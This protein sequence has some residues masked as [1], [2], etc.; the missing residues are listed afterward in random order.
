GGKLHV[1]V[2]LATLQSLGPVGL[3]RAA[4]AF[5]AVPHTLAGDVQHAVG[6]EEIGH[7]RPHFAVD[8]IAIFVL[9][10]A[11]HILVIEAG[12]APLDL[13]ETFAA[14]NGGIDAAGLVWYRPPGL[15]G[16]E[17]VRNLRQIGAR[18]MQALLIAAAPSVKYSMRAIFHTPPWRT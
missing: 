3:Q 13:A 12:D 14:G 2:D 4:D 17:A 11:H 5:G 9:Q 6:R 18:R 10:V 16:R 7:V 15:R 1:V 8:V